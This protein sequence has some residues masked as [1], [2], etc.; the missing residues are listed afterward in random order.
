MKALLLLLLLALPGVT[1]GQSDR[2]SAGARREVLDALE[3]FRV[4]FR[5][6]DVESLRALLA[7]DYV[8]TNDRGG[9]L[10]KERW[11]EYAKARRAD[12]ASG[13][14]VIDSYTYEDVEVRLYDGVAVVTGLNV[15]RGKREGED[16]TTRLRFTHVWVR[17]EGRWR[18]AAFHDS[19]AAAQ[20]PR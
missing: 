13:K 11:L 14:I 1:A 15:S 8:H 17:R 12:L 10:G 9:V 7:D 19:H 20:E 6:A 4:A 16:F 2:N 3:R 18:R 5:E